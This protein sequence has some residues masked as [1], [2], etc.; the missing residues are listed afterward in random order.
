M[1]SQL[2]Y[3]IVVWNVFIEAPES[4]LELIMGSMA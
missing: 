4:R 3:D 1:A 2:K